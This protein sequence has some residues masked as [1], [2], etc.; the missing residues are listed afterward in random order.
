MTETG[1]SGARIGLACLGGAFLLD[2]HLDVRSRDLFSWMD[3]YQYYDFALA[4]LQGRE[5]LD[6]FEIPSIF[7]F[8]VMPLLAVEPSIP[9]ALWMPFCAMFG[10]C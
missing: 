5:P 9:A 7:P 6:G 3:P 10:T 1:R 8:F 4:A 2:F